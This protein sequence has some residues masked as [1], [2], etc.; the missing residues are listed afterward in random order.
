[1]HISWYGQSCFKIQTK[2]QRGGKNVVI[3]TD[4][5]DVKSGLR[6]PQGQMDVITLSNITY[7]TKKITKL[8]NKSF[9]IDASGE[10]SLA[11]VN[12]EG[13]ESWQDEKKEDGLG[14]NTIFL[15]DSEGIR[16]CHLGKLG[17]ALTEKQVEAIGEVDIL[18]IPVGNS[19]SL[20][21][22]AIKS[23][24]GQLEP[25]ILI[26]MDYKVKGLKE[27]LEDCTIFCKEFGGSGNKKE[28]K[29]T[30]KAK[31]VKDMENHLVV[32]NVN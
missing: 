31:D 7:R 27:K 24:V 12:I 4:I 14:R 13:I 16:I 32:L 17:Q 18:L 1:M 19:N 28:D 2:P 5:F 3:T 22:K 6:P 30:I 23:I 29:L 20:S 8:E 9:V 21:I 25:G 26:P 11:G 10:Y 15:I